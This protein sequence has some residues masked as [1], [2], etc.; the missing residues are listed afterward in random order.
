LPILAVENFAATTE[1]AKILFGIQFCLEENQ[2]N[3]F[4]QHWERQ[5]EAAM[6]QQGTILAQR[7][8]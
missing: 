4:R 1:D 6:V 8:V 5:K 3:R 2:A 7:E